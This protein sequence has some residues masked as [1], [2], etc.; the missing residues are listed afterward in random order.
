MPRL[1]PVSASC[2]A[3]R[4]SAA[5]A[6]PGAFWSMWKRATPAL[7]GVER[8]A[9]V[10]HALVLRTLPVV[11]LRGL[12]RIHGHAVVRS[13]LL[14]V[15]PYGELEIAQQ[16]P[17]GRAVILE[18][19][20]RRT[21]ALGILFEVLRDQLVGIGHALAHARPLHS[22]QPTIGISLHVCKIN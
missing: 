3:F 2:P 6:G 21:R 20:I 12:D 7:R 11:R 5:G 9:C 14:N 17:H 22:I 1:L 10:D 16:C 19:R 15:V 18:A 4:S 8:D 13:G